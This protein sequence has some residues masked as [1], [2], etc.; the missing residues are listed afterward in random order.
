MDDDA[1]DDDDDDGTPEDQAAFM[2][3][4]ENFY[5]ERSMD[6]KPPRFY[7]QPLNCLKSVPLWLCIFLHLFQI[8]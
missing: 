8:I 5:R 6:F 2:R 3:E 7:G 4:I 1:D